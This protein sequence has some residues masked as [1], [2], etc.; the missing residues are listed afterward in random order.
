MVRLKGDFDRLSKVDNI[1]ISIPYG[2]IKSYIKL[3]IALRKALIS[4]PYGAIILRLWRQW[5]LVE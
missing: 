3:M 5:R 1:A 4:I 2:A